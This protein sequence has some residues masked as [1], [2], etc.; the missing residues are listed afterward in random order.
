MA[1]ISYVIVAVA[2]L[3][4]TPAYAEFCSGKKRRTIANGKRERER[5]RETMKTKK[6]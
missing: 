4:A 3:A 2:L 6:P 1:Y 5:E